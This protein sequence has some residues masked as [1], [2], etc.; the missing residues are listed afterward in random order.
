[1]PVPELV[2]SWS[3]YLSLSHVPQILEIQLTQLP[4]SLEGPEGSD[5]GDAAPPE[6]LVVA[7]TQPISPL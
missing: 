6:G 2:T 7:R 5:V 3:H 4:T 1:M